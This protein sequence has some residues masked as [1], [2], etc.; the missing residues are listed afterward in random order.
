MKI[1]PDIFKAYDVRGVFPTELDA[2]AARAI[3]RAYVAYLDARRI[4]VTRDMRVSSPALAA[5]FIEGVRIAK[6][7]TDCTARRR[8]VFRFKK[9]P[10]RASRSM[11]PTLMFSETDISRNNPK[12]FR[13]SVR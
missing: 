1:S 2:G 6:F 13:S 10:K 11:T 9:L 12:R 5:A 3:G 7:L 4:A 8:A